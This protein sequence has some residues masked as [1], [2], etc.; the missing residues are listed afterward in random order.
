V[1]ANTQIALKMTFN[2]RGYTMSA[3][4][5][6]A[7]LR[8]AHK[9]QG[10]AKDW[11][12]PVSVRQVDYTNLPPGHYQFRVIACNND[13]IWNNTGA[14]AGIYIPPVFFRLGGSSHFA[15]GSLQL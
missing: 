10:F 7:T 9:L 14:T 1:E 12:E 4:N 6:T 2:L 3:L 8:I 11:S 13:G 5:G 15:L